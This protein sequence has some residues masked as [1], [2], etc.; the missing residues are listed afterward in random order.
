M[1]VAPGDL[2]HVT[3]RRLSIGED[4]VWVWPEHARRVT[5]NEGDVVVPVR[6]APLM[7]E[8]YPDFWNISK[9]KGSAARHHIVQVR[10]PKTASS[11]VAGVLV[12]VA[13]ALGHVL[14]QGPAI[15]YRRPAG[16]LLLH[17]AK[18]SSEQAS[19]STLGIRA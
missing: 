19:T 2:S 11:T 9:S 12:R 3:L 6:E 10:I 16:R 18:G 8:N 14:P 13:R 7:P 4:L 17:R 1:H 15:L 5:D